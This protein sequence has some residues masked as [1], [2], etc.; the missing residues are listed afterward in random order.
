MKMNYESGTMH[1]DFGTTGAVRL[2]RRRRHS[3]LSPE[4]FLRLSKARWALLMGV[5]AIIGCNL[6]VEPPQPTDS[7]SQQ[8]APPDGGTELPPA[9]VPGDDEGPVDRDPPTGLRH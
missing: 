6:G 7:T 3:M 2:E 1:L 9:E 4:V 8:P 5:A